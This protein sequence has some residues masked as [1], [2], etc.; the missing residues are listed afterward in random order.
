MLAPGSNPGRGRHRAGP[1]ARRRPPVLTVVIDGRI[2]SSA[3]ILGPKGPHRP[4]L[5]GVHRRTRQPRPPPCRCLNRFQASNRFYAGKTSSSSSRS[6]TSSDSIR[7]SSSPNSESA[8]RPP[9]RA[10]ERRSD[11]SPG[12]VPRR[13]RLAGGRASGVERGP[14]PCRYPVIPDFA[15]RVEGAPDRPI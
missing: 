3:F 13:R 8:S 9:P 7:A 11:W 5:R 2:R 6:L 12:L 1:R 10:L 14:P 4:I 15:G